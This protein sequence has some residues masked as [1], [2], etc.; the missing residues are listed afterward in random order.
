VNEAV[1]QMLSEDAS[2]LEM[3]DKRRRE[4]NLDF[5]EFVARLKLKTKP[6]KY[7]VPEVSDRPPSS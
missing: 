6:A 5:E 1:R 4:P 2:D 7:C 3:F